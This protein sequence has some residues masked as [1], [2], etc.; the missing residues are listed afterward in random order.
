MG[1]SASLNLLPAGWQGARQV[2]RPRPRLHWSAAVFGIELCRWMHTQVRNICL[3]PIKSSIGFAL[4]IS[5]KKT[6]Q[7]A[8]PKGQPAEAFPHLLELCKR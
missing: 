3:L 4:L 2:T 1:I 5:Q 7:A 8:I 6:P